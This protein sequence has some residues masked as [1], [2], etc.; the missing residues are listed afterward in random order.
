MKME[1]KY[2]KESRSLCGFRYQFMMQDQKLHVTLS[3]HDGF[4]DESSKNVQ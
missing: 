3:V 2:T 1:K 4:K